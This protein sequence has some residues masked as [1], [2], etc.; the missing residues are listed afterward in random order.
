MSKIKTNPGSTQ[1]CVYTT[2][3]QMG[4]TRKAVGCDNISQRLLRLSAP[5]LAQPLTR[6][7]NHFITE[8][9]WPSVWKSSNISPIFKKLDETDK[10]N[11]RPVSVLT[12]LFKIYEKIIFDQIYT[13]FHEKLSPNLSGYLKGHSCCT[14]LLKMTEDWRP[15]SLDKRETVAAVAVDLSKT[16]D[17]VCHNLLLAKLGAY[18]FSDEAVELMSSY[19]H[20]RP[21][22]TQW[23]EWPHIPQGEK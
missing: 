14:A 2:L 7:I 5:A 22:V 6:L 8:R 23:T 3:F 9:V 19:L 17:T 4:S 15:A 18:G 16:F 21:Q 13:V 1:V 12:A 10:T 11:Y 20:G